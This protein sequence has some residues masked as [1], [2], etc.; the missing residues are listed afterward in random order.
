MLSCYSLADGMHYGTF[1]KGSLSPSG[2]G[3]VRQLV[4]F[5]SWQSVADSMNFWIYISV[6]IKKR[7]RRDVKGLKDNAAFEITYGLQKG[8]AFLS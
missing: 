3:S 1:I 4:Y 2:N 5:C 8:F 7:D 6:F